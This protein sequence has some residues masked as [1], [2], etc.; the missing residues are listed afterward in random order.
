MEKP[1]SE[2]SIHRRLDSRNERLWNVKVG[3]LGDYPIQFV[4]V[5][6]VGRP[7]DKETEISLPVASLA[8]VIG[9]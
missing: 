4:D 1:F 8:H 2:I 3:Q 7:T 5:D 9:H 6:H